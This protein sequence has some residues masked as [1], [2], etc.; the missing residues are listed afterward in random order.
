MSPTWPRGVLQAFLCA[1]GAHI[2]GP[3]LLATHLS[4]AAQCQGAR[5]S[6]RKEE[7]RGLLGPTP[8]LQP[9]TS[10]LDEV[11]RAQG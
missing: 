5:L 1:P 4:Q 7:D 11:G 2:L 10:H 6:A 3:Q 8:S 9:P